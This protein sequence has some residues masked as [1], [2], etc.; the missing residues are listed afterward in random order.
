[1][2][3]AGE[4]LADR[5]R[6]LLTVGP[7]VEERRMFGTR[8]FFVD[9]HILAGARA[10]GVLLIRV[11]EEDEVDVLQREGASRATMGSRTMS[12][13]WIDVA[14]EVIRDDGGLLAW[15]DLARAGG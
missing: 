9:D 3:A 12:A 2:D 5:V 6:A 10:G 8:A 14:P 1:M 15:L 7:E 4:E 13:R 11:A